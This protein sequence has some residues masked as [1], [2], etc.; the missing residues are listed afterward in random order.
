[1]A[2]PGRVE[3]GLRP[4][5]TYAHVP[6]GSTA[7][8]T[9]A[10]TAQIER[11]APGFRDVVVDSRCVPA[12]RMS[13]MN[14]NYIGGG[15]GVGKVSLRRM[16]TGPTGRLSPYS[17]GIPGVYRCSAAAPPAPGVHGMCG[18]HAARWA[19]RERFD[20]TTLPDLAP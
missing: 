8:V 14:A 15:I 2:D 6:G 19:L 9:E 4:L 11:F 20:T 5:W 12:V 10:V 7:D 17:V 1:A 3:E 16:I 18:H 13:D